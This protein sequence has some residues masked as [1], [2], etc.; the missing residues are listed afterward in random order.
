MEYTIVSIRALAIVLVLS[1]LV[2][3]ESLA[4]SAPDWGKTEYESNCASCHGLDGKGNGPLSESLRARAADLTTLAKR[5]DGVF[6]AQRV[7]EIIDERQE[8]A[9][10]GPRAMPVWGRDYRRQ[11]PDIAL[12]DIQIYG[13]KDS[14]VHNK[15]IAL[16]D[17]LH[18][19]QVK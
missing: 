5:N 1:L 19:L 3:S 8:V 15:L 7:Y 12:G 11:V 6:P 10:H 2:A 14:V 17:Y 16:V 4:Q 18:R 9:A 13:L